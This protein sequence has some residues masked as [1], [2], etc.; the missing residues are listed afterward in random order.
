MF[1]GTEKKISKNFTDLGQKILLE[2]SLILRIVI[3]PTGATGLN[4]WQ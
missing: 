1:V 3:L 2:R 4:E